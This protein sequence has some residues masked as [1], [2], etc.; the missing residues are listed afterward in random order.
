[1]KT[2]TLR[3]AAAAITCTLLLALALGSCGTPTDWKASET[4][5]LS[6]TVNKGAEARTIL[7]SSPAIAAYVARLSRTGSAEILGYSTTTSIPV[8][9]IPIGT[10]NLVV[11]AYLTAGVVSGSTITTMPTKLLA[12]TNPVKVDITGSTTP[13]AQTLTLAPTELGTGSL[14]VTFKWTKASVD[15]ETLTIA[16]FSDGKDITL[17]TG[18]ITYADDTSVTP[19]LRTA[20]INVSAM[21]SAISDPYV[22]KLRLVKGGT[23][24][25]PFD[26][27]VYV[28]DNQATTSVITIADGDLDS[29]PA[30]PTGLAATISNSDVALSWTDNA[31]N[32]AGYRVYDGSVQVGAD[33]SPNILTKTI[34]G[35]SGN[36]TY[37]VEAFNRFGA[38]SQLST[39]ITRLT[40]PGIAATTPTR[41]IIIGATTQ[42][43]VSYTP[44]SGAT[45]Q[46]L[47][48]QSSAPGVATVS[49]TGLVT[50]VAAGSATITATS[51]DGH[52]TTTW[53]ISVTGPVPTAPSN[54]LA[55]MVATN[56]VHLTW[57]DN[58]TDETAYAVYVDGSA[59]ALVSN[60][61][62]NTA[63][64]DVTSN[65][66]GTSFQVAAISGNG[67]STKA[68]VSA[69]RLSS[70]SVSA[71]SSSLTVGFTTQLSITPTPSGASFTTVTYASGSTSVATVNATTGLV[72][73]VSAGT[74]IIT[75][76]SLDGAKT[77]TVTITVSAA[78][79]IGTIS[80]QVRNYSTALGISGA[81]VSVNSSTFTAT[82]DASG[83]F[84]ITR[85]PAGGGYTV[86]IHSSGYTDA[87]Y[88]NVSVTASQTITLDTVLQLPTTIT[89]SGT[90]SGTIK[91]GTSGNLITSGVVNLRSG[92]NNRSSPVSVA[93]ADQAT[94]SGTGIYSFAAHAVGIYTA[95]VKV[96]TYITAYF[97]VYVGAATNVG[98]NTTIS[99]FIYAGT[100]RVVLTWDGTIQDLDLMMQ[101]PTSNTQDESDLA[102]YL[103]KTINNSRAQMDVDCKT[104]YG[105]ETITLTN[106]NTT[107]TFTCVVFNWDSFLLVDADNPAPDP[108]LKN[109][110]TLVKVYRGDVNGGSLVASFSA[111]NQTG[112][113]WKAFTMSGDGQTITAGNTIY[114]SP[115]YV[116]GVSSGYRLLDINKASDELKTVQFPM[117]ANMTIKMQDFGILGTTET[118]AATAKIG[119]T[120]YLKNSFYKMTDADT[121]LYW[122]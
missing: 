36:K 7:P 41:S 45:F 8:N 3:G 84:S 12:K 37:K 109:S 89:G 60:L 15:S 16:R 122:R 100:M 13:T 107:A 97:T 92:M 71:V 42:L 94:I 64:Y 80:G 110:K 81:T 14:D 95:E 62:A 50:G 51:D 74:A 22:L 75:A 118:L 93:T 34:S 101:V 73:A 48:Y 66:T 79:G 55:S 86:T 115:K 6:V 35:S 111:P 119:G 25:A 78:S 52:W 58:A 117:L 30:A 85:V 68:S 70:L 47:S 46:G 9:S 106:L 23:T 67:A 26:E 27:L 87:T 105:P 103:N 90:I 10:W 102:S 116:T 49:S 2:N 59:T 32:E 40:T 5:T 44:S 69:T 38:S 33:L 76:T 63:T 31:T 28:C 18:S 1:M 108:Q 83:N 98:Q 82:T 39:T 77:G 65:T 17:A 91:D 99:P 61:A 21:P 4:G 57:T 72:T 120:T 53:S 114:Q 88:S 11:E 121:V 19:N 56:T 20:R 96:T 104:G 29:V 54:L 113:Y 112:D 24:M 43:A